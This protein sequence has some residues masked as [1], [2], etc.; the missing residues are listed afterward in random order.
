MGGSLN[1]RQATRL[2]VILGRAGGK[3]TGEIAKVLRIHPVSISVIVRRFSELGIERLPKQSNYKQRK[4]LI[5]Q[6]VINKVLKVV[7]TESPKDAAQLVDVI[8]REA[9][10]HQPYKSSSDLAGPRT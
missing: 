7:Q 3:H 6:T 1:H 5:S 9:C 8:D 2:Q 4:A 10:R